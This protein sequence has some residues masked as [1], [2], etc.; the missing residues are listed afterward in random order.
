MDDIKLYVKSERDIDTSLIHITR[1]YNADIDVSFRLDWFSQIS[2]RGKVIITEGVELPEGNKV[3]GQDTENTL[4]SHRQ[5]GIMKRP[6][7]RQPQP[8]TYEE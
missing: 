8:N 5:M 7:R 4:G 6:Q 1:I 3:D 2:K